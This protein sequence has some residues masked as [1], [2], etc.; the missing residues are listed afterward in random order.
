MSILLYTACTE[1]PDIS[2]CISAPSESLYK[3]FKKNVLRNRLTKPYAKQ[4]R[5]KN[6][7]KI[8]T[9]SVRRPKKF[10]KVKKPPKSL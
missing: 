10:S 2:P 5:L 4:L 1:N 3:Y 8:R 9:F 6:S 7:V